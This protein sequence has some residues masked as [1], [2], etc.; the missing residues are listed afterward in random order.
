MIM[1]YTILNRS[2]INTSSHTAVHAV[3]NIPIPMKDKKTSQ[4]KSKLEWDKIN[5]H[6][7]IETVKE[8]L[9]SDFICQDSN[10]I[11]SQIEILQN[12][13]K[14]AECAAVP[15][16]I[17]HLKGPTWKA[18]PTVKSMINKCKEIHKQWVHSGKQKDHPL[19]K[20]LKINK[21][22][23]RKQQR[24]EKAQERSKLYNEIME[25]PNTQHFYRLI[26]RNRGSHSQNANCLK[27]DGKYVFLPLEQ[28]R[29][30]A[31]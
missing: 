7:Y 23:L 14:R 1:E 21:K 30:F 15:S 26:K 24:L 28:R 9:K 27:I 4:K 19:Q 18:S 31:K 8:I 3:T 12:A 5:S 13:V 10:H 25:N 2:V 22:Q 6:L 17:T 16:K 20:Q 29:A 11:D